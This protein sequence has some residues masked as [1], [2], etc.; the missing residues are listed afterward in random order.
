MDRNKE[1]LSAVKEWLGK[2]R[3]NIRPWS[4]FFNTNNI[5]VPPAAA[6][7]LTKRLY[8]NVEYFLS[9]YV[10]VF[11]LLM[12]LGCLHLSPIGGFV[13]LVLVFFFFTGH[14]FFCKYEAEGQGVAEDQ[15]Q[16]NGSILV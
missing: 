2:R 12:C 11:I 5:H 16:M 14:T 6:G 4:E 3:A 8:K 7:G 13:F 10:V 15:E 9:N 1:R